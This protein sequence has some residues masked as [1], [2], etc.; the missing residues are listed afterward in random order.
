MEELFGEQAAE[1]YDGHFA[2][3]SMMRD[4]LHLVTQLALKELPDD[5]HVLS[6]GAGTGAEILYLSERFPEWRFTAVEPSE[7]MLRRC[8]AKAEAAG[9]ASR[10]TFHHGFIESLPS[11][12]AFDGATSVLVSQFIVERDARVAFF[13]EIASRLRPGAPFLSA[14]LA[15]PEPVEQA[16]ALWR[17]AWRHAGHELPENLMEAFAGKVAIL[18]PS[19]VRDIIADAG[20][21][22][23][24]L[25]Y[26]SVLIHGWLS[27]RP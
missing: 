13:R 11:G 3:L 10:C 9:V 20:F 12:V 21:T 5:A 26:Q 8:R 25:C 22:D 27:R 18:P 24:L 2:K 17:A 16:I 6:V 23:P 14:D 19:D 4:A 1:S 15:V 7:P